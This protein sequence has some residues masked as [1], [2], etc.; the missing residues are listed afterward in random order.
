M[1]QAFSNAEPEIVFLKTFPRKSSLTPYGG[2]YK[3][4]ETG[5]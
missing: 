5:N 4:P 1:P 2:S 3:A